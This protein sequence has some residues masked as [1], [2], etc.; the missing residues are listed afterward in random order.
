MKIIH[1][2][3]R[4]VG[5]DHYGYEDMNSQPMLDNQY[6]IDS[7]Y[8]KRKVNNRN[9]DSDYYGY[10]DNNAG[11]II[12]TDFSADDTGIDQTGVFRKHKKGVKSKLIRKRKKI[13]KKCK[14]K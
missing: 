5:D 1:S 2:R 10:T 13:V 6:G 12:D 9:E 14:C 4:K 11:P 3:I 8:R 7:V